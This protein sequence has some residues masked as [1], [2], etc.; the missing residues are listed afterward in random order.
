LLL[1]AGGVLG[2]LF[3]ALLAPLLF[4]DLYEYVIALI[5]ACLLLPRTTWLKPAGAE[6]GKE[7]R[8]LSAALDLVCPLTIGLFTLS[9]IVIV[10]ANQTV[11]GWLG[12]LA[13]V[14]ARLSGGRVDVQ[15]APVRLVLIYG[16][17]AVLCYLF[18]DRPLR[19]GLAVAAF[20][21]AGLV[22][23]AWNR[24]LLHKE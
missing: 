7:A 16:V 22:P 21:L 5:L 19:F 13:F 12:W 24:T 2:G 15:I 9:L 4:N 3:N 20:W 8:L 11:T 17:P 1:S 10:P 23:E 14:L 6:R 18:V